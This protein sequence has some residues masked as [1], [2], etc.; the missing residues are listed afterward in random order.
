MAHEIEVRDGQASMMYAGKEVPWHGLGTNVEKEVTAAAAIQLADL[1]WECEK[2][3]I[4]IAGKANVDGIP[5][6]GNQIH[7]KSAI[8]RKIDD[9]VLGVT[10]DK[11]QIIQNKECFGFIDE[12]VGSGQ[13][14][15]HTA[16]SLFGGKK[17]FCTIKF[18]NDAKIGD[19]L[20]QKYLLLSSSHDGKS[21]LHIQWTPVRVVCA[22]T[23]NVA[24]SG[25]ATNDNSINV[26]HVTN[27]KEKIE[28]AR[29]VLQFTEIYYQRMEIEF[30]RLLDVE[31]NEGL[32]VKFSARLFPSDK[33]QA[34]TIITKK[35]EKLV[36]LYHTGSG[37]L[38]VKNTKWA[39]FNAVTDYVDHYMKLAPSKKNSQQE[40]RMSSAIYG[41]G[42]RLKQKAYNILQGNLV[43]V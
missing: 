4:F 9:K 11:Y 16:A 30:N 28:Q 22:N 24:L 12:V 23:L 10:S 29:K 13:A 37:N 1:D 20:I 19:D 6:I 34:P 43:K 17:I 38:K 32:M 15:F 42:S 41:V 40:L 8:V 2:R 36:E 7:G 18:P 27:Y 5:V 3:L 25:R 31:F 21:A 14:I 35:R 33:D 26:A 39:A